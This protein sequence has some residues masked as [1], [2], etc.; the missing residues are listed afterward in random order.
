[1]VWILDGKRWANNR[2]RKLVPFF[3]ELDTNKFERRREAEKKMPLKTVEA[4]ADCII[5]CCAEQ[6]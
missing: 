6:E 2:F 5:S 3:F 1:M 4:M